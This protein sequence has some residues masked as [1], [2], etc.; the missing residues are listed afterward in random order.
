MTE[1]P[2]HPTDTELSLAVETG[3]GAR[4]PEPFADYDASASV[5]T[6]LAA[7]PRDRG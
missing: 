5:W 7:H 6:F 1:D 2:L 3:T 4:A